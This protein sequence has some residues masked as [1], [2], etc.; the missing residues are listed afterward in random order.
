MT[1]DRLNHLMVMHI[2]KEITDKLDLKSVFK[3]F[4]GDSDSGDTV[5]VFLPSTLFKCPLY[6]HQVASAK[7]YPT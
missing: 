1:Q 4:T 6:L 5:L 7:N 2:H 3:N